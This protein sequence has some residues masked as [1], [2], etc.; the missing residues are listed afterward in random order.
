VFNPS[1]ADVNKPISD[2]KFQDIRRISVSSAN[3]NEVTF[4][5][6]NYFSETYNIVD[7]RGFLD[8]LDIVSDKHE[9]RSRR[10]DL[11]AKAKLAGVTT[12][13]F[14]LDEPTSNARKTLLGKVRPRAKKTREIKVPNVKQAQV[15]VGEMDDLSLAMKATLMAEVGNPETVADHQVER[16]LHARGQRGKFFFLYR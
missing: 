4:L 8:A 14:N 3:K 7:A 2:T 15:A 1:S 16:L 5:Q 12:T 13:H 6:Q 11:L 10:A 9:R